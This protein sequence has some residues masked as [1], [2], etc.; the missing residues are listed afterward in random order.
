MSESL[1]SPVICRLGPEDAS[2]LLEASLFLDTLGFT[3]ESFGEDA[4]AVRHIPADIDIG[5]TESVL[6]QMC[7]NL[8]HSGTADNR[9]NIYKA[10]ACKAAIKA[11]RASGKSELEA[12]AVKV[13]SGGV[14]TCPHGRPVAFEM[15]KS[16]LDK[17]FGKT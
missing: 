1:I 8:K 9:D 6:S 5:D 10:I 15:T 16:T 12:L 4:V 14:L 2:I 11:G 3:V 17:K 13:L 7:P